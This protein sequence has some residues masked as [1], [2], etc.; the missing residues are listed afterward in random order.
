MPIRSSF[1]EPKIES[2]FA[3]GIKSTFAEEQE[4]TI[5]GVIKS[6]GAGVGAGFTA[7]PRLIG[8]AAEVL[9]DITGLSHGTLGEESRKAQ[10]WWQKR[11]G[12]SKAEQLVGQAA[13]TIGTIASTAAVTGAKPLLATLSAGAG[14]D[15]TAEALREGQPRLNA[16]GAGFVQAG[17]EYLTEKIPIGIL[18]KPGLNFIKRLA[19]GL[20]TDV[21]GELAAAVAEMKIIDEQILGKQPLSPEQFKQVLIDTAAVAALSTVG[22]SGGSQ[23]IN[24]TV[25]SLNKIAPIKPSE[26]HISTEKTEPIPVVQEGRDSSKT[27]YPELSKQDNL[28]VQDSALELKPTTTPL[29]DVTPVEPTSPSEQVQYK[30][31]SS[32]MDAGRSMSLKKRRLTGDKLWKSFVRGFVDVSGNIQTRLSALGNDG[33]RVVMR[34]NAIGGASTKGTKEANIAKKPIYDGL[35]SGQK[36]VF[37]GYIAALRHL[38]IRANKG[39]QFTLPGNA[40]EQMLTDYINA[41]PEHQAEQFQQRADI[42][43]Q[44]MGEVLDV[45]EGE[46]LLSTEQNTRLKAEGK[47]YVPRQVLDF[48]DPEVQRKNRQGKTITS[49]DSGLK[50]LTEDGSEKLIETDSE[51]LLEQVYQRAWTRIFKNRANLELL[52]LAR[53]ADTKGIVREARSKEPAKP[54][55]MKVSVMENGVRKE[56]IMPLELGTEWVTGDPILTANQATV[57]GWASGNKILKSMATTLNPEFAITNVPR[58]LSHIY[59]TT[60]EYSSL[61]PVAALQMHGDMLAVAKDAATKSGLY[62]IYIDNGGGMEFLAHQGKLGIKGTTALTKGISALETVMS[63][64][65]EFSETV[66][67]LALM[68]RAMR[69]GKTPFEATQIAR[70]YLDFARGGSISKLANSGIPFFNA[71]VQATRGIARAAKTNPKLFAAKVFQIASMSYGLYMANKKMY[72]DDIEDVPDFE[73]VNN[74]VFLTPYTFTDKN[75]EDRRY[76]IR[77]PKDQGQRV[78]ATIAESMAKRSEGEPVDADMIKQSALDFLPILPGELLPPAVEMILGYSVNKDFWT[79]DDI[80]KG[81]DVLPQEEYTKYTPEVF[82]KA[83]KATGLSPV[84][85]RYMTQQL[86]TRGNVWT[87]L[88]GYGAEQVFSELTPEQR[89]ELT[90]DLLEKKPGLKRILRSTKPGL[91]RKKEIKAEKMQVET[92]RL[93]TN[94][95]FDALT[96]RFFAGGTDEREVIAYLNTRPLVEKKR[97]QRRFRAFKRLQGVT[98]RGFW[99]DLLDLPPEQRAVNYWNKWVQLDQ[100]RRNELDRQ[101][102]KV[103]GFRSKRFNRTFRKMRRFGE[104]GGR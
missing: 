3:E 11:I 30:D 91:R 64:A 26:P 79:K 73:R 67:R 53:T 62:D 82:V 51:L 37:D 66:T 46:G 35:N 33:K 87:S 36:Q 71:G 16:Y 70:G 20:V 74:W 55:E 38:E 88:V 29:P 21:P 58:D 54:N 100:Q 39:A 89:S 60:E 44:K 41:V 69:N 98:N 40:T 27:E 72:G 96:E 23:A 94:R 1:V 12:K 76:Y 56:L 80:W 13:E 14:V 7:V 59:L 50:N 75:G 95:E 104:Q 68:R 57:I 10:E 101:S 34:Q 4:T 83:G 52:N 2:S 31:W 15:K 93:V 19:G 5:G 47:Y 28:V 8:E 25:E 77:I 17:T 65:G 49:R 6:I 61:A 43:S 22:L 24:S 90:E 42:W 85:L 32:I 102:V 63:K 9:S 84:R 81:E 103:P 86:F 92:D 78:F 97:L 48:I 18:Q 99:F 45:M